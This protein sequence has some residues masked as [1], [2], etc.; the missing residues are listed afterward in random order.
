MDEERKP[1]EQPVEP[2]QA[3]PAPEPTP[4]PEPVPC[5][6]SAVQPPMP[7]TVPPPPGP[8][9]PSDT[10][11]LI[12]LGWVFI[13]LSLLTCCCC[14]WVFAPV[15]AVLGGIAYSRGDQ[16]GLWILIIGIVLFVLGGGFLVASRFYHYPAA[17]DRFPNIPGPWRRA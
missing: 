1:E 9:P 15:A 8:P 2:E 7:E 11:T 12:I 3:P 5:I 14:A 16:R 4:P 17:W 13:G 6:P 10:N